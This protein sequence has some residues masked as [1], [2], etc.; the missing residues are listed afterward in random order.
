MQE[1]IEAYREVFQKE[2]ARRAEALKLNEE[3]IERGARKLL[4]QQNVNVE[5]LEASNDVNI[6][7]PTAIK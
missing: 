1:Y 2:S 6:H 3:V 4:A 5:E 7:Q